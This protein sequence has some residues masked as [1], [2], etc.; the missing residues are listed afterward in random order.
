MLSVV[1]N[2]AFASTLYL[3]QNSGLLT[4]GNTFSVDVVLDT[5]S[6]SING[7]SA[8][9]SYPTDKLEVTGIS[10]GTAFP[11]EAAEIDTNGIIEISRG[12]YTGEVGNVSVA[13]ISFIAKEQGQAA[14]SFVNGSAAPRTS[15]SSD[16]LDLSQSTGGV[17]TI[18]QSQASTTQIPACFP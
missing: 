12:S 7:I 18:E 1:S 2:T 14:I 9:L 15:D 5:N 3:S 16:S 10:Y 11:V 6:E 17:F 8:Y 4:S 13:T